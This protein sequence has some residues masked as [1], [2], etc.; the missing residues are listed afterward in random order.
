MTITR[1]DAGMKRWKCNVC[2]DTHTGAEPPEKCAVC[3]VGS[4]MFGE[5]EKETEQSGEH[6]VQ[7]EAGASDVSLNGDDVAMKKWR[8]KICGYVHIGSEPP[9][10]CPIC[11]VGANMFEEV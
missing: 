5:V 4:H 6:G 7:E 9:E 3:D 8:C 11:R 10:K 1:K 2:G